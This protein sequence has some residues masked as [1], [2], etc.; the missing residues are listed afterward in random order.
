MT[1]SRALA[2]VIARRRQSTKCRISCRSSVA[3]S[4]RECIE[5]RAGRDYVTRAHPDNRGVELGVVSE[6]TGREVIVEVSSR[7]QVGDGI[8]F[9]VENDAD[10]IGATVTSVRTL[11]ERNSRFRQ[12]LTLRARPQRGRGRDPELGC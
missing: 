12:A 11:S 3:V 7:I 6:V 1:S 4:R 8:A 10:T 5:G 9:E 2:T